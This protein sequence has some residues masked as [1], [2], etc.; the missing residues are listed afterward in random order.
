MPYQDRYLLFIEHFNNQKYASAQS[1]L[2]EVWL[3]EH[4]SDKNF[5]GGL[6]QVAVCL[7]HLTNDN[8]KGA[9]KIFDKAQSMLS[10]F[11][12]KHLGINVQKLLQDMTLLMAVVSPEKG[13]LD[14]LKASPKIQFEESLL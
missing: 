10:I 13:N 3:D 14:Y 4:G 11:G 6:V 2:D 1:T 5:Y 9:G 8:P 7:Y 12:E